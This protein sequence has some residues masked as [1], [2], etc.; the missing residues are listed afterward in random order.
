MIVPLRGIGG[1][2][3]TLRFESPP[4]AVFPDNVELVLDAIGQVTSAAVERILLAAASE[5]AEAQRQ[6]FF[7]VLSHEL[8]TPI[9]TIYG[10]TRV[11]SQSGSRLS[12]DAREALIGDISTDAERLFRLIEDLLVL[13]RAERHSLEAAAEPVLLQHLIAR[14]VGAEQLRWPRARFRLD[15][16]PDLPPV[17]GEETWIEQIVRNLL[18]NAAKYAGPDGPI[19]IAAARH[20]GAVEIVVRDRGMGMGPDDWGQAFELFY[21]APDAATR[22][23]GAGIGLYACRELVRAMGGTIDAGPRD[24]GGAEFRVRLVA[25]AASDDGD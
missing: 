8:R 10:G 23:Q 16:E 22:A 7:G 24:G 4:D 5:A 20:D 14:V 12:H 19:E 25:H 18:S 1:D 17:L 13:S 9:T 21:R 6:A 2:L 15:L 11:L 3:G